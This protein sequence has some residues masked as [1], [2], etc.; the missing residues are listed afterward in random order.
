MKKQDQPLKESSE[1]NTQKN[2]VP[3]YFFSQSVQIMAA[4]LIK[5]L[6]MRMEVLHVKKKQKNGKSLKNSFQTL[7]KSKTKTYQ[8]HINLNIHKPTS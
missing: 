2:G 5:V 1:S 7:I 3:L 8:V 6:R 4:L